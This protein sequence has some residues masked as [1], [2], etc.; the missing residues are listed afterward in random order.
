[1]NKQEILEQAAKQTLQNIVE[2]NIP[3]N[4]RQVNDRIDGLIDR[5]FL[6]KLVGITAALEDEGFTATQITA[7]IAK[8][9]RRY[10]VTESQQVSERSGSVKQQIQG[11]VDAEY[12]TLQG[13]K[14]KEFI[15]YMIGMISAP[16]AEV[17]KAAAD[18]YNTHF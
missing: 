4:P 12:D 6:Q 18:I 11:L 7:Y 17:R 13:M 10:S 15:D 16:Q 14:K 2:R 5:V 8:Q 1:M 3:M 9:I